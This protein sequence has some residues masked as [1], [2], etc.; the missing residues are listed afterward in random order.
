MMMI[1]II[2]QQ[3]EQIAILSLERMIILLLQK[4]SNSNVDRLDN[5]EDYT[6][7]I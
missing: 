2:Q 3:L 5:N 4:F 1:P 7:I 6:N